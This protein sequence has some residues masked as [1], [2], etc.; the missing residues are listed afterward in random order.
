[1]DEGEGQRRPV[2]LDVSRVGVLFEE[3]FQKL[4]V[5]VVH[6]QYQGTQ[7]PVLEVL[8][9]GGR[10]LREVLLGE[11]HGVVVVLVF[12]EGHQKVVQRKLTQT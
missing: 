4:Q 9:V 8:V 2:P 10:D 3:L 1:M 7:G 6:C 11:L 5:V 12:V